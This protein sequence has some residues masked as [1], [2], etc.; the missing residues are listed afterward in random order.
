MSNEAEV[1]LAEEET[2]VNKEGNI[3]E[4]GGN[5]KKVYTLNNFLTNVKL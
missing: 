4:C 1:T 3:N 5:I 2:T